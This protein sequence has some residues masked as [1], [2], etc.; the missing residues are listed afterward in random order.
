MEGGLGTLCD[1]GGKVMSGPADE[2]ETEQE[3]A[4]AELT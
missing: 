3:F 2:E 1:W 4:I